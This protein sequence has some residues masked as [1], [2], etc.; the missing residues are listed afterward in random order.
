LLFPPDGV[1]VNMRK[2][3]AALVAA[4]KASLPADRGDRAPIEV[5]CVALAL[6]IL[7]LACRI[8]SFW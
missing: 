7:A 8:A 2:P 3:G 4:R 6:A 1:G 5:V